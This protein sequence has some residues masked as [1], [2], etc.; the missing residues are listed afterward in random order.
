MSD[1]AVKQDGLSVLKNEEVNKTTEEDRNN[2]SGANSNTMIEPSP[3]YLMAGNE[4]GIING[5]ARII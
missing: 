4:K 1:P 2:N 3:Q 5:N